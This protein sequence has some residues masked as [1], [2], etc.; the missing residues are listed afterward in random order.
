MKIIERNSKLICLPHKAAHKIS[1]LNRFLYFLISGVS[2]DTS[3]DVGVTFTFTCDSLRDCPEPAPKPN[4]IK[5]RCFCCN[6]NEL[7]GV[8]LLFD[9]GEVI[10]DIELR[11]NCNTKREKQ[12][13]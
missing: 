4:V 2:D 12:K 8:T 7:I 13:E 11:K 10:G 5:E 3:C 9:D 1:L 6:A